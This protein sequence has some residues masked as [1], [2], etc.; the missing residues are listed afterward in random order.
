MGG[1]E[2][3]C[4]VGGAEEGFLGAIDA[5]SGLLPTDGAFTKGFSSP[6]TGDRADEPTLGSID[7]LLHK[8]NRLFGT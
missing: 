1:W 4:I 8:K 6:V 2:E 3:A 7:R 5:V